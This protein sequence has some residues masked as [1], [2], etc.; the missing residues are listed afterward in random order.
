MRRSLVLTLALLAASCGGSPQSAG[1]D[2]AGLIAGAVSAMQGVES[3]H[4]EMTR[5]GAPVTVEGLVFDSAVGRYAAPEAAEA[6]LRVHVGGIAVELGT[7]SIGDQTWLTDPLTGRWHELRPGAGFNPAILFDPEFGWVA[8]LSDLTEV[9]VVEAGGE[10]HHLSGL[11]P[12]A[13]IE[14]ITVGLAPGQSVSLDLWLDAA[15]LHI[16][17]LEFSTIGDE[18]RSDWVITMSDFGAPV[19]IDPPADQ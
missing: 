1:L 18:G 15:T 4:F 7:V 11:V 19:Q 5:A 8:L 13:R 10:T 3:A 17:R 2:A 14:A 12:A 6:V 16:V 9:T